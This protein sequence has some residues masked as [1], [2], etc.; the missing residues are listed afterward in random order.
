MI[1]SGESNESMFSVL[2]LDLQLPSR[3]LQTE[4]RHFGQTNVNYD[5]G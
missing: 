5:K 1:L 4:D 3:S 2:D